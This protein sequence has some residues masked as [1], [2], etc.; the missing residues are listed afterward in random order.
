MEQ[1]KTQSV[2]HNL[3]YAFIAAGFALLF[4]GGTAIANKIAV[5]Y[6]DG[7]TVGVLRSMLAG[8]FSLFIVYAMRFP[9]PRTVNERGLLVVSGISSFAIWPVLMS[10]GIERTTVGHAA[11]IM[12]L[13]PV[14]TVFIAAV[15]QR[16]LPRLGWWI[17]AMIAL[18][19][20]L[21]LIISQSSSLSVFNAGASV[22]GDLLVLVGGVVCSIGYVAGGRL[23]PKIGTAATTFWGLSLALVFLLPIFITVWD[24]SMWIDVASEAYIAIAWMTLF[25][26]LAGYALWFYALGRGGIGRIG[27]LQLIMPVITL[28]LAVAVLGEEVPP[29]LVAVCASIVIGT[30]FAHKHAG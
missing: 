16:R 25:S 18:A 1:S 2:E 4:W 30:F 5:L 6:M 8:I 22:K 9:F 12:A 13:I 3:S 14:F 27:T 15:S 24:S 23:S 17:G 26:S 21:V 29:F 20:T 11:L 19:A 7:L 10:L 28:A